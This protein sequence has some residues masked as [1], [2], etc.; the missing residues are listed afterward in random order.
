L[1][2][3]D[4]W[5]SS[6]GELC[7]SQQAVNLPQPAFRNLKVLCFDLVR[8]EVLAGARGKAQILFFRMGKVLERIR[9]VT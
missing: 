1:G 8:D 9:K 3:F 7:H 5:K 6:V 4:I 2:S